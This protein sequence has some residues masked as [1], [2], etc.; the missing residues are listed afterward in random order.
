MIPEGS[1]DHALHARHSDSVMPRC[2]EVKLSVAP[3]TD[4]LKRLPLTLAI[5]TSIP[6]RARNG[7]RLLSGPDTRNP[8][9]ESTVVH[10]GSVSVTGERIL[11]VALTQGMLHEDY[12]SSR[13]VADALRGRQPE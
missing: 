9:A 11:L 4:R 6:L 12:R 1:P 3:S 7:A 13:S 8:A 5:H 2:T 10:A